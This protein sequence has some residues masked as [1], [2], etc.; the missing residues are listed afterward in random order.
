[1]KK[2][3]IKSIGFLV[4]LISMVLMNEPRTSP[5][6]TIGYIVFWIGVVLA[7]IGILSPIKKYK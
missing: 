1:M 2:D 3:K 7:L 4:C 5:H 6:F